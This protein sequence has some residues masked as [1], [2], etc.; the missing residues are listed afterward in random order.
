MHWFMRGCVLQ[1]YVLRAP[2]PEHSVTKYFLGMF[3]GVCTLQT[4]VTY[5]AE[6]CSP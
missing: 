2:G 4:V 1:E 3:P 5:G 6:A